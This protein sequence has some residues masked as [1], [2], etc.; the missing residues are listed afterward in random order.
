MIFEIYGDRYRTLSPKR[1]LTKVYIRYG[2]WANMRHSINHETGKRERGISVY[3]ATITDGFV[4][5][6]EEPDTN[7][8]DQGRL[9]FAVTGREVGIGSDDE[10]LLVGVSVLT[11][12]IHLS[13][14]R[15]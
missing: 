13:A 4:V 11:L 14:R 3:R 8:K 9:C 12:P 10:P 1:Q 6:A 5:L 7:L 15:Y 2:L